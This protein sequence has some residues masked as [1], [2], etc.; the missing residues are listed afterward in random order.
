MSCGLGAYFAE[1]WLEVL[2]GLKLVKA[3]SLA[4]TGSPKK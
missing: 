1:D 4:K 3:I 2:S